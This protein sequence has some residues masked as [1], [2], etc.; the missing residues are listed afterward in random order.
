MTAALERPV[1]II[2]HRI[3]PGGEPVVALDVRG[4]TTGVIL[5]IGGAGVIPGVGEGAVVER[6]I[7]LG[8]E[9]GGAKAGGEAVAVVDDGGV[10]E[11]GDEGG[12]EEGGKG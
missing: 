1:S 2:P 10:D 9:W 11:G 12:D 6:V 4:G 7:A 3:R 5:V 8:V